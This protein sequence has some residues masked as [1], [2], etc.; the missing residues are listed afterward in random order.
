MIS[1]LSLVHNFFPLLNN[2]QGVSHFMKYFITTI[3]SH[4]LQDFMTKMTFLHGQCFIAVE[5]E[6]FMR[7]WN[8]FRSSFL[9]IEYHPTERDLLHFLQEFILGIAEPQHKCVQ[10]IATSDGLIF[11]RYTTLKVNYFFL[12]SRI[13]LPQYTNWLK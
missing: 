13:T 2:I 9:N 11:F 1:F 8:H 12:S 6:L 4:I 10:Y 5:L 3:T 7:S